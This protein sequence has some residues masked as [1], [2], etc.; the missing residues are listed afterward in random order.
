MSASF[1]HRRARSGQPWR[2]QQ[3]LKLEDK[4]S[5]SGA[6][7]DLI[8]RGWD[9]HM[10]AAA[11]TGCG[12]CQRAHWQ[13]CR[14]AFAK[15]GLPPLKSPGAPNGYSAERVAQPARVASARCESRAGT[16]IERAP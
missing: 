14:S 4:H 12:G 9:A 3:Y 11:E 8:H 10:S 6:V 7:R 13:R 15:S 2:L 1:G 5:L 16:A